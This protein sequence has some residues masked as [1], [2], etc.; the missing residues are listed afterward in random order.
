MTR[1]KTGLWPRS[2]TLPVYVFAAVFFLRLCV[3]ARFS[4]SAFLLP[5]QGDMHFYNA[6]ALRILGGQLTDHHAFY[7]LPLYPYLLAALYK[8]FGYTPYLPAF[9]QVCAESATAAV[10]RAA[11]RNS[12]MATATP[13]TVPSMTIWKPWSM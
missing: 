6:W 7:G 10:L 9:L 4:A 2:L 12:G 13:K 8:L 1:P 5:D 11:R 3:L